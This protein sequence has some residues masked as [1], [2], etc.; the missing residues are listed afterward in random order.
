MQSLDTAKNMTD[1]AWR[2]DQA[3][4]AQKSMMDSI[5]RCSQLFQSDTYVENVLGPVES[6]GQGFGSVTAF[7]DFFK[8]VIAAAENAQREQAVRATA[9]ALIPGLL[10][11]YA[12]LNHAPDLSGP[13]VKYVRWANGA[14]DKD[15]L[16]RDMSDTQLGAAVSVRRWFVA[17]QITQSLNKVQRCEITGDCLGD[18]L[19]RMALENLATDI[20]TY[21]ELAA[22]D[23]DKILEALNTGIQKASKESTS[24]GDWAQIL[25]GLLG[26]ADAIDGL[27]TKYDDFKTSRD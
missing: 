22:I 25:D 20:M 6:T 5:D 14:I 18:P 17:R 23:T 12:Q 1:E 8:A 2:K 10:D 19:K 3:I 27:N 24:N 7:F 11:A 4:K 15:K 13:H 21:R 9:Q 26:A 16:A